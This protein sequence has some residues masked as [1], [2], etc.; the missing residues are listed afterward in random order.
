MSVLRTSG[1]LTAAA[2]ALTFAA[3]GGGDNGSTAGSPAGGRE[4]AAKVKSAGPD[5][6]ITVAIAREPSTLDPYEISDQF[7]NA[8]LFEVWEALTYMDGTTVKP[9][10]AREVP[11]QVDDTTW[12]VKLVE[13]V[14]FSDGSDFNADDVVYSIKR[15]VD[16]KTGA[17]LPEAPTFQ[18]AKRVDEFTV[19]ITTKQPDPLVASKLAAIKILP[20]GQHEDFEKPLGTGPYMLQSLRRGQDATLVRNPSYRGKVPQVTKVTLKFIPDTSTRIK[21]LQA[22]E[23]DLITAVGPDDIDDVPKV[24]TSKTPTFTMW[25][26]LNVHRSP[27]DDV[28]VRQA[29]NYAIDKTGITENLFPDG[30]AVPVNCEVG[31]PGTGDASSALKPY[32]YDPERAKQ[33]IAEAGAAGKTLEVAW[34]SGSFPLDREV[35]QAVVQQLKAVGLNVKLRMLDNIAILK[36]IGLKG[37]KASHVTSASAADNLGNIERLVV[38]FYPSKGPASVYADPKMDA[39]VAKA[40]ALPLGTQERTAAFAQMLK[41][42]CD[43]AAML[44][45][46]A[47]KDRLRRR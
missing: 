43:Q 4:S 31:P 19:H 40:T 15:L 7:H 42:G 6:S 37:A 28:R 17:V 46:Y 8:V 24:V 18:G 1:V 35:G 33:L 14:E 27:L 9:L 11:K 22:G 36:N 12:E 32:P 25:A 3:C 16:P 39:L 5:Q 23:V 10:L 2:I 41:Y 30:L 29:I 45:L 13:G 26:R 38:T 44:F 21:A 20:D 34:P 47:Y